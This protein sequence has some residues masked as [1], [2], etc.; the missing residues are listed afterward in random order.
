MKTPTKK[1]VESAKKKKKK[2]FYLFKLYLMLTMYHKL[3]I[4]I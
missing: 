2:T 3:N 1:K 4:Y